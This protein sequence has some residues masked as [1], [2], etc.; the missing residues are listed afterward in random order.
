MLF[1]TKVS[2]WVQM[3]EIIRRIL[4]GD[5][6]Y[7]KGSLDF[8]CAKIELTLRKGNT[9]EGSFCLDSPRGS[10]ASGYVVS[11]DLR[12]E[13]LTPEFSGSHAEIAYCFHGEYL[14]E[15]DVV[16]GAFY[17]IS[18]RGEHHLPFVA[19]IEHEVLESSAGSIKNLFHFAN[20][21][22]SNWHEAVDLFHAPEFV[23]I[24]SGS[25][26]G[27]FPYYRGLADG[28][29]K[30]QAVEEFL[31]CISKKRRVD[32]AVSNPAVE[33]LL[34]PEDASIP[35]LEHAIEISKSGWGYTSLNV[36]C[37]GDFFFVEKELLTE[38]D[39]PENA[40]RLPLLIDVPSCLKGRRFGRLYLFNSY[41]SL[42]VSVEV[43]AA[44]GRKSRGMGLAR[45]KTMLQLMQSYE[46]FRLK[47]INGTAWMKESHRLAERLVAMDEEDVE[48]RLFQAQVLITQERMQEAGWILEHTAKLMERDGR[49]MDAE[50]AYH[51]Y[52]TTLVH[53]DRDYVRE[54]AGRVEHIYRRRQEDWRVAW[55]LLYLPGEVS[56]SP[57]AKW[58]LLERQFARGCTSPLIYLEALLLL[59]ANPTFMRRMGGFALQV[60]HYG[61]VRDALSEGLTEQILYLCSRRREFS[62]ALFAT[63]KILYAKSQDVHVL[64]EICALLIGGGRVGPPY[65]EWYRKGVEAQLRITNLYESYMMSIDLDVMQPIPRNVL[66]YFSYQNSLDYERSAYLYHYLLLHREEY[67]ELYGHYSLQIAHFV[68]EQIQKEHI[69][70]HLAAL[71][72][73]SLGEGML[74]SDLINAQMAG[75]LSKLLFAH[76]IRVEDER[77]KRVYVYQPGKVSPVEYVLQEA[78][79]WVVLYGND[80]TLAFEDAYGNRFIKSKEYSLEKLMIPGRHLHGIANLVKDAQGFYLY[81][82]EHGKD[83]GQETEEDV[84]R[85][86]FLAESED[87]PG[88]LR[89]ELTMRLLQYHYETD[90]VRAL[91]K[92]LDAVQPERLSAKERDGALQYMVLQGKYR[93]A[94]EW[95]K[96][97]G[98][99][100][101]DPKILVRL[102]NGAQ[103]EDM[104]QDEIFTA[105]AHHAFSKGK[106]DGRILQYL[107]RNYRGAIRE[108]RDI[109]RS[110]VSFGVDSYELCE[111]MLVQMLYTGA[112]VGEKMDIFS[113]YVSKG[114]KPEVEEAFLAQCSYDC[115]VRDKIIGNV[116]FHKIQGTFKR[117][118]EVQ[119]IC[120]LAFL[121]YYSENLRELDEEKAQIA[122]V[123][124]KEVAAERIRMNF[125]KAYG[126][127]MDVGA[128]ED[129]VILEYRMKPGGRAYIH[130]V[131][132][133]EDGGYEGYFSEAMREVCGGVYFKEFV[134]FFGES[135]QYY[136]VEE[137]DGK[138]QVTR[139]G[140]LQREEWP[141]AAE[142]GRFGMI[143]DMVISK[144]MPDYDTLDNLLED[145]YRREYLNGELFRM[146]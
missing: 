14:E 11:S 83:R 100:F 108:M 28:R 48:A 109:W 119:R 67:E 135:V 143:N 54:A 29:A 47:K 15:G 145:Y 27:Y 4:D 97:Y 74:T 23:R 21:A 92:Y 50:S 25:D 140:I 77:L 37:E 95:M 104:Q 17:I 118:E 16:K 110:A 12:M 89:N 128:L 137:H 72:R 122:Q 112:Y 57:R 69:N 94:Y 51:L 20:L 144:N 9:Y 123:F 53:S 3:Q 62:G 141:D 7:E 35:V 79:I 99:Y 36:E 56:G 105:A 65:L 146:M 42:T 5:F 116:V 81:L 106:Y 26:A 13:C 32:Y 115:F 132:A 78:G 73:E 68:T 131:I 96:K 124:L 91:D 39:F 66:M 2:G 88:P 33:I 117:R 1:S 138:A 114:A 10:A 31:I 125:L 93:R 75:H 113:Y 90:N 41:V 45:K 129:K 87:T 64:Q 38:E 18:N 80:C 142:S 70:R 86:R 60:V 139:S 58:D 63:L 134:L 136:I 44:E 98:P 49:S 85:W 55:L 6:D 76:W 43:R 46:K 121:K 107:V 30:E 40:C 103:Q 19:S 24:F 82:Y 52:L 111:R 127:F 59:N 130:Y 101:A 34:R 84:A 71:Y 8:S 61:A 126:Q 102:L 120:K 133:H 22:Q